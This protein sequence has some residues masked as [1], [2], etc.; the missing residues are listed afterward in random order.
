MAGWTQRVASVLVILAGFIG[1][2]ADVRVRVTRENSTVTVS[3]TAMAQIGGEVVLQ[4]NDIALN[5]LRT[6]KAMQGTRAVDTE[7][8]SVSSRAPGSAVRC[9]IKD[10][11]A[12]TSTV[13]YE[14]DPTF[15][16]TGRVP[17][18]AAEAR[19]R[20][21]P[22]L[23]ILRT[24]CFLPVSWLQSGM[25]IDF[26][27]PDG[28]RVVTPWHDDSGTFISEPRGLQSLVDYL[29]VGPF[30][31]A[32][33]HSYGVAYRIAVHA[34]AG[35]FHV[36]SVIRLI[37]IEQGIVGR[38]PAGAGAIFAVIVTPE[39]F[40]RG[41]SSGHRSVVQPPDP[42]VLA[43]EIFHW[44]THSAVTARE[45]QWYH[46]GFTEYVGIRA[47][48]DAG[49]ITAQFT[50]AC[51]ADLEAEM[52]YLEREQ[53]AD[54]S[55]EQPLPDSA[56]S[57]RILYAKGALVALVMERKLAEAGKSL[58]NVLRAVLSVERRAMTNSTLR[59]IF[60]DAVDGAVDEEFDRYITQATRLPA[61]ELPKPTGK[62]GVA[63]FLPEELER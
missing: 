39:G 11:S 16:P 9:R 46:E 23:G 14:V 44:W 5:Q 58:D 48:R 42:V 8:E 10:L 56:K 22:Q 32:E 61:L 4:F 15:Y 54:L 27:V 59:G 41:G 35:D 45:A 60:H 6:F 63:R 34:Q 29:G 40:V 31:I 24:T 37:E 53:A 28:W 18:E 7:V 47:S 3:A 52:T 21:T 25:R 2:A 12:G 38:P 43:H 26:D 33:R 50:D 19:S 36:D 20:L 55:S 57:S 17:G 1:S 30:Q 13:E 49:L 51:F 62:T